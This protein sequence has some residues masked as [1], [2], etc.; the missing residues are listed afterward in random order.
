MHA[1][2]RDNI[3][4]CGADLDRYGCAVQTVCDF[5]RVAARAA[6]QHFGKIE[7]IA[8]VEVSDVISVA[9]LDIAGVEAE[10]IVTAVAGENV[11]PLVAPDDVI[12]A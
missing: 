4:E 10:G 5:Q 3:N 9:F 11:R 8:D 12:M 7:L 1:I 6:V 2:K